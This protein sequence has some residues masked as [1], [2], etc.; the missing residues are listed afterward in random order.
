MINRHVDLDNKHVKTFFGDPPSAALK[1]YLGIYDSVTADVWPANLPN[2]IKDTD[3]PVVGD[4]SGP[5][6]ARMMAQISAEIQKACHSYRSSTTTAEMAPG[7][8]K[9]D[10]AAAR[11]VSTEN[12]LFSILVAAARVTDLVQWRS[13]H[14]VDGKAS[15]DVSVG[16]GVGVKVDAD[17]MTGEHGE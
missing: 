8:S 3:T 13:I 6:H 1:A 16:I 7:G 5:S 12:G 14:D 17:L 11:E 9:L 2:L 15:P 4:C 10:A